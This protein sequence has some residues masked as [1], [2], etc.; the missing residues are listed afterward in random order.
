MF[1]LLE[2]GGHLDDWK[3]MEQVAEKVAISPRDQAFSCRNRGRLALVHVL[4][5]Y[6]ERLRNDDESREE[7]KDVCREAIALLKQARGLY[8]G[9]KAKHGE[10]WAQ[11]GWATTVRELA[12]AYRLEVIAAP[13]ETGARDAIG[14]Y[15]DAHRVY[16]E[17]GSI[18]GLASLGQALGQAYVL[19]GQYDEAERCYRDSLTFAESLNAEGKPQHPRLKGFSLMRFGDLY[20][21][22][23]RHNDAVTFYDK[24][25]R[26]F[27]DDLDDPI[28]RARAL[29]K[30]GRS[31]AALG[32]TE[33]TGQSFGEARTIFVARRVL[34]DED[35]EVRVII[36]WQSTLQ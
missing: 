15:L 19:N 9:E 20:Q 12:D 13:S 7:Q 23:G 2:I 34:K 16:T 30:R 35:P 21:Q 1:Y 28:N 31:L 32:D 6:Q 33:A 22:L 4:G 8:S 26:T 3:A 29:A 18:N 25:A 5:D 27:Q 17:L 11:A 36:A 24:C 10:R 14:N